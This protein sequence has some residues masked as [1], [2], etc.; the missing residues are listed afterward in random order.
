[1]P[2]DTRF[3]LPLH[4]TNVCNLINCHVIVTFCDPLFNL[5]SIMQN[6]CR[7]N[8]SVESSS[9][10]NLAN[11]TRCFTLFVL[12]LIEI[13][14]QRYLYSLCFPR[15]LQYKNFCKGKTKNKMTSVIFFCE[16]E[17]E[18]EH[19]QAAL[20]WNRRICAEITFSIYFL[21]WTHTVETVAVK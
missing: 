2:R 19:I 20:R 9:Q 13:R 17:K 4:K 12:R 16:L 18:Y 7:N 14:F 11:Q 6:V 1:M 5:Y 21:C 15:L 8:I 3:K 10:T